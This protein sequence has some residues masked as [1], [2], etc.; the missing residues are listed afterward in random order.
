ML[1]VHVEQLKLILCSNHA[2]SV[3]Y[4]GCELKYRQGE[5]IGS[6]VYFITQYAFGVH[7]YVVLRVVPEWYNFRPGHAWANI[8]VS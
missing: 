8:H 7:V 1:G 3:I 2:P 6:G 4:A 5:D